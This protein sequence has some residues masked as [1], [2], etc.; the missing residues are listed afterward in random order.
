M[1]PNGGKPGATDC[2][3]VRCLKGEWFSFIKVCL[4]ICQVSRSST[5]AMLWILAA[6]AG[7]LHAASAA[8]VSATMQV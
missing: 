5:M 3:R 2:T 4:T 8:S 6:I 1:L 7:Y